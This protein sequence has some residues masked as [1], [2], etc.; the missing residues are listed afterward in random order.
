MEYNE[1]EELFM[2]LANEYNIKINGDINKY[3]KYMNSIIE[4]N[5]FIN[6]TSIIE[7]REFIIKHFI[8]SLVVSS[9]LEGN[10]IID[11]GTGAGFPGVPLAINSSDKSFVLVDSVN[12][13]LDVIRGTIKE[14]NI[15]NLE[16]IHCRAEELANNVEYR[17]KFDVA[18]SRAVANLTTLVE[19]ML[20]FVKV[21]GICIC[22][23][24]PNYE[25]EVDE[26][27]K[28][29]SILS[30]EIEKVLNIDIEGNERN[31]IFIRK[32][33]STPTKYPRGQG[34]PLKEPIK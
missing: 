17:E 26:A 7:P 18:V 19:Y 11:I 25:K 20:P 13:K 24:G 34:K 23:K 10:R 30:G 29:I 8:D 5:Q 28:A 32:N 4:K 6:L 21:G 33:N 2:Q 14:L 22:M 27:R 1:F 31:I 9:Y 3:Y 12:K 15:N 16:V